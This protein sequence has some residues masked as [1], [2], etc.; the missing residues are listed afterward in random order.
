MTTSRNSK[1]KVALFGLG[2]MGSNHL[3]VLS[4]LNSVSIEYVFDTD[5]WATSAATQKYGVTSTNQLPTT[6]DDIDAVVICTPTVTHQEYLEK[7]IP[8]VRNIFVEKPL[9]HSLKGAESITSLA[10]TYQTNKKA[11]INSRGLIPLSFLLCPKGSSP[12]V[13][14]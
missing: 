9:T 14:I 4:M 11:M 10:N 2:K 5:Q 8:E 6:F 12:N 3:R 13:I 7:F 1:V